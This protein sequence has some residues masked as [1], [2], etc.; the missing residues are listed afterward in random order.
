MEKHFVLS[1][2]ACGIK[3]CRYVVKYGQKYSVEILNISEKH[4]ESR[5]YHS[6]S[7]RKEKEGQYGVYQRQHM[8][9]EIYFVEYTE[10]EKDYESQ[11]EVDERLQGF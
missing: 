9:P 1:K 4:K 11:Q 6:D 10:N 3:Y 8:K 5:K 2:D 7:K